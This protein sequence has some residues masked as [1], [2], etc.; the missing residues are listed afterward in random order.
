M[1]FLNEFLHI[2]R[3]HIIFLLTKCIFQIKFIH[4]KLVRHHHINLIRH[5]SGNPV[6][7]ADCFQPPDLIYILECNSI[8]LISTVFLE[9]TSKS[10]HAFSCAVDIRKHDIYN[11]LF[12]D[13]TCNFFLVVRLRLICNQRIC[14]KHTWIGCDRFGCRHS[15]LRF[16]YPACRPDSF[17]LDC[18][19]HGSITHRILR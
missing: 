19:R 6:M 9:N 1:I 11:V 2:R 10:L 18:V 8:H 3:T 17:P 7:S 14:P 15:Y 13:S 5:F 4:S 16:I 12:P